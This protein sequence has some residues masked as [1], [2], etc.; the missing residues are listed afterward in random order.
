MATHEPEL[1]H[2]C[3]ATVAYRLVVEGEVGA[4][5]QGWFGA[6]SLFAAAGVT[7]MAIRV[8][9]QAELHGVLRRV[10]DMNLRLVELV[11]LA[12]HG[13]EPETDRGRDE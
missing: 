9:D 2:G 8:A 7:R 12:P 3:A 13:D 6:T 4:E 1:P 5:W 10:H 11:R